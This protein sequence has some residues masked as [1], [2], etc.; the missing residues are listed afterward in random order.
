MSVFP[1]Y[2]II[3]DI[4]FHDIRKYPMNVVIKLVENGKKHP[5]I[6]ENDHCHQISG[7]TSY[8]KTGNLL[9]LYL[10]VA[11]NNLTKQTP[12]ERHI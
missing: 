5:R 3:Y 4:R 2:F 11:H 6:N 10:S 9:P 12:L 8:Q 7:T 1:N